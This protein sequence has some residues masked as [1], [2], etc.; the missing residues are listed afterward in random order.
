LINE[1]KT[2][3]FF[4]L[5]PNNHYT[6]VNSDNTH[7]ILDQDRDESI[8]S[9]KIDERSSKGKIKRKEK[10]F[11]KISFPFFSELSIDDYVLKSQIR[12][13]STQPHPS[14]SSPSP[15]PSIASNH[16]S[17][18]TNIRPLSSII[19]NAS[20]VLDDCGL[21]NFDSV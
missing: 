17:S 15:I 2:I 12:T 9:F 6:T 19:I 8:D 1:N 16:T 20:S 7:C 5:V 3:Y 18:P 4:L 13:T 21:L 10:I 11:F 14:S